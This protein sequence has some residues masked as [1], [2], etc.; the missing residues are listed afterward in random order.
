M[1]TTYTI[2][3]LGTLGGNGSLAN[4][5]NA[6]GQV[7]GQAQLAN[8][9]SHA[10]LWSP[11]QPGKD[12][13]TLGGSTSTALGIN[14]LGDI[15]GDADTTTA[16]AQPF[17]VP[18]GGSMTDLTNAPPQN[19]LATLL[20]ARGV[21]DTGVIV[22]QALFNEIDLFAKSGYSFDPPSGTLIGL[23]D[24][25]LTFGE[26]V[27]VG[28]TR[29]VANLEHVTNQ[30]TPVFS[31]AVVED[32]NTPDSSV[33]LPAIPNQ[34]QSV[35]TGIS[36]PNGSG[37]Q[38][39]SGFA[40]DSSGNW[41]AVLWTI[42]TAAN[43]AT[44]SDLGHITGATAQGTI[45]RE[46]RAANSLGDVV[47]NDVLNLN[48]VAWVKDH[49]GAIT[50]LSS[51]LPAGS[52][53]TLEQANGINDV[54]QICATGIKGGQEHAFLLTPVPVAPPQAKLTSAPNI[55][56]FGTTTYSFVVSYTDGT[57][58]D[59]STLAKAI[60]V[61]G[62]ANF[63]QT[64]S[65]KTTSGNPKNLT[66]TYTINAPGGTWDFAD[67]GT[68]TVTL[69]DNV[70]KS[71]SGKSIAGGTLGHFI[72]AVAPL[73][74]TV[75]GTVFND[76]NAN[77]K[78]DAGEG[79]VPNTDVFLDLNANGNFDAGDRL[80]QTDANGAY[81][82]A[83]LL[84]GNYRVK[85][86]VTPPHAVISPTNDLHLVTLTSGQNLTGQDFADVADPEIIS[87]AGQNLVNVHGRTAQF[88]Q[89]ATILHVTGLNLVSGDIFY[90]GND[91]A[92]ASR[93]EPSDRQHRPPDVRPASFG[94]CHH[95]E[96]CGRL[97]Q[98]SDHDAL[99]HVH[100]R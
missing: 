69:K 50:L 70:V 79:G 57:G 46:A 1:L 87:I 38:F 85:E 88:D 89:A 35:A 98:P 7:V 54:G 76:A 56:I 81:T 84:P 62:P 63:S 83:G 30:G 19:T 29:A 75:S 21:S 95:R 73:R 5:I 22:G 16:I 24:T 80:T 100:G 39:A 17:E 13:G 14:I 26:A 64:A 32:I 67:D 60:Q 9:T 48:P 33:P 47:G 18:S 41:H 6:K 74:A 10:V 25:F 20:T 86:L 36:A 59:A 52:G 68:Y 90:F 61:T 72:T 82:F 44:V 97:P 96:T 51:L 40:L 99:A 65:L 58:I 42:P 23:D 31:E 4:A 77:G 49:T 27:A 12:L 71:T 2:V 8:G 91:Q 28:G 34:T 11:G 45:N 3:D 94:V 92:P 53:V 43:S 78:R 37:T 93:D 15:V 55:T 66:A